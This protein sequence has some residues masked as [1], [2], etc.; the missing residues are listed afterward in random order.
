M[1][2]CFYF[3]TCSPLIQNCH[4]L[5][6]MESCLKANIRFLEE[7]TKITITISFFEIKLDFSHSIP[8]TI[9]LA[10]EKLSYLCL[11]KHN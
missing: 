7:G 5:L 1:T 2:S 4:P 8:F 11:R 6:T 3:M 9:K 10:K